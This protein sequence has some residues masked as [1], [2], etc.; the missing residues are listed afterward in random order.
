MKSFSLRLVVLFFCTQILSSLSTKTYAIWQNNTTNSMM[1][2][3]GQISTFNFRTHGA[4]IP[5]LAGKN[6]NI[7]LQSGSRTFTWDAVVTA[8]GPLQLSGAPLMRLAA[9][10]STKE[11]DQQLMQFVEENFNVFQ[12]RTNELRY[13]RIRTKNSGPFKYITYDRML[14]V[15]GQ[16][17]PVQNAYITFRFKNNSLI[18]I[19]NFTYGDIGPVEFPIVSRD[20]AVQEVQQDARFDEEKDKVV[21]AKSELQPFYDEAGHV[22]FRFVHQISLRKKFPRGI[23]HYSVSAL[24][25]RIVRIINGVMTAQVTGEIYTR[26]PNTPI[27]RV[28]LTEVLV[29]SGSDRSPTDGSGNSEGEGVAELSGQHVQ[30]R[31]GSAKPATEQAGTDGNINFAASEHISETMAYVHVQ[32]VNAYVRNFLKLVSSD[33]NNPQNNFL[34]KP[35]RVNT[36]VVDGPIQSCNAWFDQSDLTLNFL[37]GDEKCAA[38]SHIADVMYHEWG[39][40]LDMALGGINDSAFSEAVG[41]ITALIMTGDSKIGVGFFKNSQRPIRDISVFKHYPEDARMSDPHLQALVMSG[42]WYDFYV[43]VRELAGAEAGRTKMAELFFK[44]LV[45]A[46]SMLESYQG[47]L[48]ADDDDNNLANGTPH[49]CLLNAAFSRHGLVPADERCNPNSDKYM[50]GLS[51]T[52]FSIE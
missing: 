15:E 24:D 17:Y 43:K 5:R 13:N 25:G 46:E 52:T 23:F 16:A 1:D 28:P 6:G 7:S 29:G 21:S 42:A 44:H 11:I 9:G 27:R 48:V 8:K 2:D 10:A 45:S 22:R 34:D 35:I 26:F 3:G 33:P 12:V 30:I 47:A 41:D 37:E 49:M 19:T 18:Q 38:S 50:K 39:H 51:A 14:V 20:E 31:V 40:A 4:V 36:R 32:R